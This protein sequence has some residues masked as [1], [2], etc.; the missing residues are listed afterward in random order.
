[1]PERRSVGRRIAELR[2][3]SKLTQEALARRLNVSLRYVQRMEAGEESLSLVS[4]DRL[5]KVLQA[6]VSAFFES[7]R[8][9]NPPAGRPHGTSAPAK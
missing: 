3:E 8:T 1:L 6:A 5:A 2:A 7:P 9:R 4:L